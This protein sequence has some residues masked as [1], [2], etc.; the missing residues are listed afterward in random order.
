[1]TDR[2]LPIDPVTRRAIDE[3]YRVFSRYPLPKARDAAPGENGDH[4]LAVLSSAPLRDLT[5]AR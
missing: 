1:M 3:V 5:A 2:A 4:R